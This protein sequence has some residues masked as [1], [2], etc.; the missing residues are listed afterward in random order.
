MFPSLIHKKNQA[1]LN[2]F[3]EKFVIAFIMIFSTEEMKT[4]RPANGRTSGT[5][6]L[7]EIAKNKCLLPEKILK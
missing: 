5:F 6:L 1:K 4:K 3:Y 2:K 7:I